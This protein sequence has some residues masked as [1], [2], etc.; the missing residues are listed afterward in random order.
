VQTLTKKFPYLQELSSLAWPILVSLL[1]WNLMSIA[2]A[3]YVARLG[4]E[5]VAA[6]GL[7]WTIAGVPLCAAIGLLG[8][9]RILVAQSQGTEDE[10]STHA[11]VW[12]GL[13]IALVLG[14]LALLLIPASSPVLRHFG[15][16]GEVL[17][18]GAPYLQLRLMTGLLVLA[19]VVLA[20]WFQGSGDTRTPMSATLIANITNI[21]LDPILI[22][23]FAGFEGLGVIGAGI[24]TLV[25]TL[26]ELTLLLV[27]GRAGLGVPSTPSWVSVR[28]LC[29]IGAPMCAT[30][31]LDSLT[32]AIIATWLINL[33]PAHLAAHVV[34][35]RI[36]CLSFLP[37]LAVAQAASVLVGHG[38]GA[39]DKAKAREAWRAAM[40]LALGV[41][42][43]FALTFVAFPELFIRP[44]GV[45]PEVGS[46][47]RQL[48]RIAAVFQLFDAVAVTTHFALNGAGDTRATMGITIGA[49][50]LV[51]MPAAYLLVVVYGLGAPGAWVGV[52][53]EILT[54]AGL[55]L[56][57]VSGSQWLDHP[58]PT[59]R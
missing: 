29:R 40:V 19:R 34:G 32:Y 8:A 31:G 26:L 49:T 20:G 2:D 7:A 27:H 37:G 1:S 25:A 11:F 18:H 48:L 38:V 33:D 44:F 10:S 55:G 14:S 46:V 13:W 54:T 4:T 5:A 23:G 30:W 35:L 50:W 12:S 43:V 21:V 15:A 6:V 17:L 41:M 9:V 22:F 51:K 39:G 47:V 16:T 3:I 58:V 53:L 59:P 24:A 45:T 52:T 57:R 56:W 36:I 42:G 28:A